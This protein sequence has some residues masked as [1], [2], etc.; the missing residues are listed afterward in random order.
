MTVS[1]HNKIAIIGAGPSG[2]ALAAILEKRG[3]F[4][5][6]IYESGVEE[7]APRG[8]CLDLHPGSAQRA[9]REAGVFDEF[10]T[11]GR[12]GDATIHRLFRHNGE[13]MFNFGEGRDAPEID[14][15]ALRKVLLSGIPRDRIHWKTGVAKADRSETGDVVLT[16]AN[17]ETATGFKL[18]VGADG[19]WSKLR[20]LVSV[21]HAY[22]ER[23]EHL[24]DQCRLRTPSRSTLA[25]YSLPARFTPPTPGTRRWCR[26]ARWAP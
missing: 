7:V 5:Y 8:G 12:Y 20:H 1:T 4:D 15:W 6:V 10:K 11:Y 26:C 22:A 16:F 21:A 14:R 9:L 13:N 2:L 18:V 19:T 3:G 23:R 17:G 25:T 24:A